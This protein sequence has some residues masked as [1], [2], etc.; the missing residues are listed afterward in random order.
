MIHTFKRSLR[1]PALNNNFSLIVNIKTVGFFE[2]NL[3]QKE[4][5]VEAAVTSM[6]LLNV[7]HPH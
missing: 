7:R 4:S 6:L 2:V 1:S 3:N 5:S